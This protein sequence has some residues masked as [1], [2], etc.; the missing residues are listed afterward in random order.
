[1]VVTRFE[2]AVRL[3]GQVEQS[4]FSDGAQH[5]VEEG[6]A[7]IDVSFAVTVDGELDLDSC[8]SGLTF[9]GSF[10]CH[11]AASLASAYDMC[12]S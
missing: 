6:D 3:D 11:V 8:L 12:P 2:V 5:V 9:R 1:V 7:R 4:V 10:S